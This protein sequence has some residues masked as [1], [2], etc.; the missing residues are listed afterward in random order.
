MRNPSVPILP[1]H[2][3]FREGRVDQKEF[4]RALRTRVEKP[5]L[6][7]RIQIRILS[8][9]VFPYWEQYLK[10]V[11]HPLE[12]TVIL[13]LKFGWVDETPTHHS[14]WMRVAQVV[15]EAYISLD[16]LSDTIIFRVEL[17]SR[18]VPHGCLII[19]ESR[20]RYEIAFR[21]PECDGIPH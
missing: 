1:G 21:D 16:L 13:K 9:I 8:R 2:Q 19:H 5:L 7:D 4:K 6:L 14:K 15:I 18:G 3:P 17:C 10:A 12:E 11:T 20:G